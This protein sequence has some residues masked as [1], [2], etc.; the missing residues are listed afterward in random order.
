MFFDI[1]IY[2]GNPSPTYDITKNM[3][4]HVNMPF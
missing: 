4:Q 3:F 1:Y 2:V